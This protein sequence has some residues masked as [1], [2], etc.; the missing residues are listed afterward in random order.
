M[1]PLSYLPFVAAL[2]STLVAVASVRRWNASLTRWC[3]VLGMLALAADSVL[4]GFS[5][6]ARDASQALFW[7]KHAFTVKSVIPAI[8]L[9]FSR[10]YSRGDSAPSGLRFGIP[11]FLSGL[12]PLSLALAFSENLFLIVPSGSSA[13]PWELQLSHLARFINV[14]LITTLMLTLTNLEQT[15]RSAVGT[16]RWRIKFVV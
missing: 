3:F 4:T 6:H 1:D 2:F 8:W 13:V 9:G 11:V 7:V 15:F 5:L 14:L 10:V 12:L 16:L